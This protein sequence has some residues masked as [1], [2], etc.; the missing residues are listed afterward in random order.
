MYGYI[1][2]YRGDHLDPGERCECQ[3]EAQ[4]EKEILNKYCDK[5]GCETYPDDRLDTQ[6]G[7]VICMDCLGAEMGGYYDI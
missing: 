3:E 2:P 5:C 7:E 4:V 6:N 1:C